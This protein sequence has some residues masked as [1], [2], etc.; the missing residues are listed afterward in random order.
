MPTTLA[1]S[2]R[3]RRRSP[4]TDVTA[5]HGPPHPPSQFLRPPIVVFVVGFSS[6]RTL[7]HPVH[8]GVQQRTII[9]PYVVDY[10]FLTTEKIRDV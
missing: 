8:M 2:S 10:F 3:G 9:F 6:H 4:T 7:L 1:P 5:F